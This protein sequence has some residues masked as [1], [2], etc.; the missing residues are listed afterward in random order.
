[1][2]LPVG[3]HT[4]FDDTESTRRTGAPPLDETRNTRTPFVSAAVTASQA[5]SGDHDGV[6]RTSSDSASVWTFD[7]SGAMQCSVDRLRRRTGTQIVRP[8]GDVAA[9]P[10]T[11]PSAGFQTS[12]ATPRAWRTPHLRRCVMRDIR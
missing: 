4:G 7:P 2:K 3:D 9:A 10:T 12:V 5:P 8:S 1:M 11:A 6:P